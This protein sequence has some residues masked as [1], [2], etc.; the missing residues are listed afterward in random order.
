MKKGDTRRIL[1]VISEYDLTIMD[2]H[3]KEVDYT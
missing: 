2:V 1:N 3:S